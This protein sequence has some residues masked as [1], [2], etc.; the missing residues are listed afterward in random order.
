VEKAPPYCVRVV[1][2]KPADVELGMQQAAVAAETFATCG[3]SGRWPGP[4]GEQQDAEFMDLPEW[5]RKAAA[6]R[7]AIY[8]LEHAA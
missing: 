8:E 4:G 5:S 3:Q 7:L 6:D 2:L 1:T